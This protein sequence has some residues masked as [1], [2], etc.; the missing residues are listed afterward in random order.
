MPE[1]GATRQTVLVQEGA[2][3]LDERVVDPSQGRRVRGG[4]RV[5]LRPV[6]ERIELVGGAAETVD[7]LRH[8]REVRLKRRLL[9][10]LHRRL[11]ARLGGARPGLRRLPDAP[12][13]HRLAAQKLQLARQRPA[14]GPVA[15]GH[16]LGRTQPHRQKPVQARRDR[17]V[18]ELGVAEVL[19]PEEVV[20]D[21]VVDAVGTLEGE[22]EAGDP[23]VV[24]EG[25]VVGTRAERVEHE[26][27]A[28]SVGT[29]GRLALRP[30]ALLARLPGVQD[31][32]A[33]A[34]VVDVTGRL[35][36][37]VPQRRDAGDGQVAPG[38]GGVEIDVGDGVLLQGLDALLHP[39]GRSQK[40][41][42]LAVPGRQ[43]D[44]APR[45]PAAAEGGGQAARRLQ[46][47]GGPRV[48]VDGAV[49]PG[50]A[51]VAEDDQPVGLG[52]SRDG[53]DHVVQRSDGV[54][55][56][57]R[58]L[59]LGRAGSEV[60]GERQAALPLVRHPL[61]RQR[62]ED[63]RRLAI[64]QGQRWDLR[65]A[66]HLLAAD[67]LRTLGGGVT[68][69]RRV[70]RTGRQELH[71]SPLDGRRRSHRAVRVDVSLHIAVV[72]R[73]AVNNDAPRPAQLGLFHLETAKHL[74]VTH[75]GD[76][77]FDRQPQRLQPLE[78]LVRA[79]VHVHNLPGRLAGRP[80]AVKRRKGVL[81]VG[82]LVARV[83]FLAQRQ[84]DR[85]RL[86]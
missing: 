80:V 2:F 47:R 31:G 55:H 5:F 9:A 30:L 51:V 1:P 24:G 15:Q 27:E 52:R 56:L 21:R 3:D 54:V 67:A 11:R 19:H 82:I 32:A 78:V 81:A 66:G 34:R 86:Q 45:L 26:V 39:L 72:R 46:E 57:D 12:L 73:V 42:L 16:H 64:R 69:R 28:R 43:E 85:L 79:V 25:G 38:H 18:Q 53:R 35:H 76:P 41:I 59:D 74:A 83:A 17:V 49:G 36:D 48:R 6:E 40:A 84:R 4:R 14:I 29:A 68:G 70:S 44:R 37:Q 23:G 20:V 63:L 13:A 77:P 71:R 8:G 10:R 60:I 61:A 22:V 50:I 33:P 65:D 7:R 58:H 75:D 62:L